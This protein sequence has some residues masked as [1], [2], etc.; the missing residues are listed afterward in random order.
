MPRRPLTPMPLAQRA[1]QFMPF[2]A[3]VGFEDTLAAME[4]EPAPPPTLTEE[5]AEDINQALIQLQELLSHN[6][7]PVPVTLSWYTG[8][9]ICRI[10][11]GIHRLDP[12]RRILFPEDRDPIYLDDLTELHLPQQTCQKT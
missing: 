7:E 1:K 2:R 6:R 8:S 10:T 5:Q 4:Q 12:A 11:T 9:E 3:L